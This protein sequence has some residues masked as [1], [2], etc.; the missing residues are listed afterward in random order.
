MPESDYTNYVTFKEINEIPD[1]I[2]E[3][4]DNID[5]IRGIADELR[6]VDELYYIGCGTSYYV[7]IGAYLPLI[8][9]PSIRAIAIP[10]SETLFYYLKQ[11]HRARKA[12]VAF[13]R[14]GTTA[15]VLHAVENARKKGFTVVGIT[16]TEK[17]PLAEV[18]DH[19]VLL[20]RC[21]EESYVMT[22]SY[23]AMQ[24]A[25]L[26]LSLSLLS[27]KHR[28]ADRVIEESESLASIAE[29]VLSNSHQYVE[30]AKNTL[31]REAFVFL[32]TTMTISAALEASLKFKE[33]TRA[34]TEALY[35]LEFRHGP[36]ALAARSRELAVFILAPKD[37]SFDRVKKLYKELVSRGFSV[38]VVTNAELHG[39]EQ[40]IYIDWRGHPYYSSLLFI[41]PLYVTAFHRTVLK[42]YNPD[43]PEH[44][45]KIVKSF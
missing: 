32:G 43:K 6:G 30:V 35:A 29:K 4:V 44:L 38:R 36:I 33:M 7:A 5:R 11:D 37:E 3:V 39:E 8:A 28:Y 10:A 42:G 16:C 13:S 17:S 22:K 24:L 15:E 40:H 23:V 41:I 31:E 25:G 14:S 21:Y 19:S 45:V 18:A 26:L 12:I 34:Y 27:D 9:D 1:S 20:K 2:R